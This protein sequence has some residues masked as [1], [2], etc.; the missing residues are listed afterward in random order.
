MPWRGAAVTVGTALAILWLVEAVNL[1]SGDRLDHLGVRPRSL[2]GITGILLAPLL[3]ASVIHLL[4]NTPLFA[5]LGWIGLVAN[6]RR[7]AAATAIAW[8]SSGLGFW[9]I[10]PSNS[11]GIG[12]SGVVYGWLAY[13]IARGWVAHRLRQALV[14]AVLLVFVGF[15]AFWGALPVVP[16]EV[17]WQAHL[18]GAIGG[19]LAAMHLDARRS[20]SQVPSPAPPSPPSPPPGP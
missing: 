4:D 8:V 14:G 20:A 13:L 9:L 18:F 19:V 15:S 2:A 16:A 11:V 3:H 6:A 7:F 1:A 10:G 17:A 12:V 5:V